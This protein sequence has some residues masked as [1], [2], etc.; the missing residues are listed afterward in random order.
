MQAKLT[1]RPVEQVFAA[2]RGLDL[3]PVKHRLMDAELGEGWTREHADSIELAYKNYLTMLVKYPEDAEDIVLSKDV[4]EL[5]HTHIL[6][7]VKYTEDCRRMFGKFLHHD[8]HVGPRTPAD[9]EK[10]AALTEKTRRLYQREF[11]DAHKDA[12]WSGPAIRGADTAWSMASIGFENTAW[13]MAS[14]AVENTAWSMA[15]IKAENAAWS[16]AS[17][18]ASVARTAEFSVA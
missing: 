16:M 1:T 14:I 13:S 10:K 3:E 18:R 11:G 15:S 8:P 12:A 6:Q 9:V 7:T 5:W 2:I 4:D 17:V